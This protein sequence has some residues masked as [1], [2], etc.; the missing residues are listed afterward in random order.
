MNFSDYNMKDYEAES[1]KD[2]D[3]KFSTHENDKFLDKKS[4]KIPKG[5]SDSLYQTRSEKS[6]V[7]RKRTNN[8]LQNIHIK[9]ML[10]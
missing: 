9:L 3:I 5:S 7:K 4:L 10:E 2:V 1:N 6:M 8:N